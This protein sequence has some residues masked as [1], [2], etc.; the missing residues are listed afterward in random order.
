MRIAYFGDSYD[1]V[2]R[3]LLES[4]S[5]LDKWSVVPMFTERVNRQKA[6]A[7]ESF[8]GVPL[9][10]RTR[11]T[12]EVDRC[13]YFERARRATH[14]FVDPNT[15]LK[16]KEI[17]GKRAPDYLFASELIWLAKHQPD[18]LVMV[19]D[20]SL[21]RATAKMQRASLQKKLRHLQTRGVYC[22]AYYSHACFVVA[23]CSKA[24]V[25]RARSCMLQKCRIPKHRL[26]S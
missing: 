19:F 8:L 11:L 5:D 2:K 24:I 18:H 6:D 25:N 3:T 7:F 15:G 9:A 10:S 17:S 20:Q 1:L 12:P 13:L 4:L 14:I 21:G 23:G 16:L 22:F 26:I